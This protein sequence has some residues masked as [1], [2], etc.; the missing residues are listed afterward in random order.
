MQWIGVATNLVI[1]ARISWA[2]FG[3]FFF[4]QKKWTGTPFRF[5]KKERNAVP[6]RSGPIRTLRGAE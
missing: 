4:L 6:V 1:F 3:K 2:N 5:L